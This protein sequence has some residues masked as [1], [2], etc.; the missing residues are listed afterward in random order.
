MWERMEV[1]Q[2]GG[3]SSTTATGLKEGY[4]PEMAE[5]FVKLWNEERRA[6]GLREVK[7]TEWAQKYAD[8]R[9]EQLT[10]NFSHKVLDGLSDYGEECIARMGRYDIRTAEEASKRAINGFKNSE[11]H[12]SILTDH[13]IIEC[14]VSVYYKDGEWYVTV[15]TYSWPV[16]VAGPRP[17]NLPEAFSHAFE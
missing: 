5:E 17:S 10:R 12:W 6:L 3:G 15:N 13:D 7:I 9:A 4:Q 16:E 14:G 2:R 8:I 1:G 11:G